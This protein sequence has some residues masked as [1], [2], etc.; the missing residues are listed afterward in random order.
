MGTSARATS[1]RGNL[2]AHGNDLWD[3]QLRPRSRQQKP[4]DAW[5]GRGVADDRGPR[6]VTTG[7]P[8]RRP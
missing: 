5:H 8:R 4:Q 6:G 1:Q 7:S 2:G 3:G